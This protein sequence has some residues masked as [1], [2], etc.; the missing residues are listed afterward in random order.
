MIASL[1]KVL[2]AR[3]SVQ[4]ST[5][6]TSPTAVSFPGPMLHL[7]GT[8]CGLSDLRLQQQI[9]KVCLQVQESPGGSSGCTVVAQWDQHTLIYALSSPE[10]TSLLPI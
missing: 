3:V 5:N 4:T 10:T 6:A 2:F 7:G 8:R 9:V 1:E